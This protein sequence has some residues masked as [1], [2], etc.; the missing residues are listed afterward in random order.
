MV[1][2][3]LV[4]VPSVRI[5][6]SGQSSMMKQTTT[7]TTN[8]KTDDEKSAKLGGWITQMQVLF[9]GLA[10]TVSHLY[11]VYN[12]RYKKIPTVFI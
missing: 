4:M 5:D 12:K 10:Y 9:R 1:G 3:T 2:A 7:H 11:R 8:D 6:T